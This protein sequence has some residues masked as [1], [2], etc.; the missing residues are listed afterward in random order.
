MKILKTILLLIGGLILLVLFIGLFM[1]KDHKNHYIKRE[2]TINAPKEKVFD[3][4]KLLKNQDK[5][6]VWAKA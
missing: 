6:N 2:I 5:F 1:R 4:L 3:F